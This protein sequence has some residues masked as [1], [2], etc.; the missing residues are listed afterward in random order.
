MPFPKARTVG[1]AWDPFCLS[2]QGAPPVFNLDFAKP[3]A[4]ALYSLMTGVNWS[5]FTN[6]DINTTVPGGLYL[7]HPGSVASNRALVKL[8]PLPTGDFEAVLTVSSVPVTNGF[9][10]GLFLTDGVTHGAGNQHNLG[11]H[12]TSTNFQQIAVYRYTN[13]TTFAATMLSERASNISPVLARLRRITT[14]YSA[15]FSF[16]G[17]L[18]SGHENFTP[19]G[20]PSHFGFGFFHTTAAAI[21]R[22]VYHSL[23]VFQPT[24]DPKAIGRWVSLNVDT[25]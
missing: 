4:S 1:R 9:A 25:R 24:M 8:L 17:R 15:A 3:H 12:G 22:V 21:H 10:G 13:F 5:G 7:S 20:T 18:W 16:D 23:R 14:T 19:S 6:E 2:G 11:C